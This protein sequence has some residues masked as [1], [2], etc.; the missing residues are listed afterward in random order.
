[1][2][3]LF[4]G[5]MVFHPQPKEKCLCLVDTARFTGAGLGAFLGYWMQSDSIPLA[6]PTDGVSPFGYI[7]RTYAGMTMMVLTETVVRVFLE[8]IF[9]QLPL[10]RRFGDDPFKTFWTNRYIW[11]RVWSHVAFAAVCFLCGQRGIPLLVC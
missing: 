11:S 6:V 9:F 5:V 3:A 7:V 1:M 8:K 2:I 10:I 4:C